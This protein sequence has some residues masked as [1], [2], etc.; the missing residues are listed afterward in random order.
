MHIFEMESNYCHSGKPTV[1]IKKGAYFFC[2]FPFYEASVVR[3]RRG[4]KRTGHLSGMRSIPVQCPVFIS[5]EAFYPT[6]PP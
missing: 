2:P 6:P 5:L 3:C 1:E 4:N